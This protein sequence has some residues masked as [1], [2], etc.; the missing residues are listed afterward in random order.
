MINSI[1]IEMYRDILLSINRGTYQGRPI[2]A[3][4][5]L[6]LAIF[7][8]IECKKIANNKIFFDPMESVYSEVSKEQGAKKT[9]LFKPYYYL[10]F[11]QVLHLHWKTKPY[12]EKHPST[13][14]IRDNIDYAYLDN[15]LW[16]LLQDKETRD[17][18]RKTIEDYY[19]K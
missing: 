7:D 14:F 16:D 1:Q 8:A 3:K 18:F 9:P 5:L 17:Y 19:L 12:D 4:P 2:N 11:D 10:Q 6:L 13:K 15:A